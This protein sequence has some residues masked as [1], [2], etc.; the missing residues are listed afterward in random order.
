MKPRV[1][2]CLDKNGSAIAPTGLN[3]QRLLDAKKLKETVGAYEKGSRRLDP[4][5]IIEKVDA[6]VMLQCTPTNLNDGEPAISH[7]TSAMRSGKHVICVNKG[8]LASFTHRTCKLQWSYVAV[9]RDSGRRNAYFRIC[10][11][12]PKR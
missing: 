9:Q 1:V 10:Q 12:L 6:E 4:M 2:A 11:A 7:I 3:P 8:P 5:E